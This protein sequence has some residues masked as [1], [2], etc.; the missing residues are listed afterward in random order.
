MSIKILSKKDNVLFNR[1]EVLLELSY[2][3]SA[4]PNRKIIAEEVIR[5]TKAQP[6][7]ISIRSTRP[8]FGRQASIV[9]AYIYKDRKILEKNEPKYILDRFNP[10]KKE[11]EAAPAQAAPAAQKA[12]EK[13]EEKKEAKK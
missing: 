5:A 6:N 1:E 4:T 12:P 7:L 11:G 9:T 3:K 2:P 13:K 8:I 10:P